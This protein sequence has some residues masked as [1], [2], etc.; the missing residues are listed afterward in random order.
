[1]FF[2]LSDNV[3]HP[4]LLILRKGTETPLLNDILFVKILQILYFQRNN[5]RSMSHLPDDFINLRFDVS[6]TKTTD[7]IK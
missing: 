4:F 3:F 5:L 2:Y 1:M 7:L 6:I